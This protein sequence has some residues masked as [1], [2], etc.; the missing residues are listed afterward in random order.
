V[1][2]DVLS[3]RALGR[4]TLA[5]QLLLVRS[6]LPPLDAIEHLVGLQAQNPGDPYLA[7]W[8]RLD[9]F[10]PVA[11]GRLLEDRRTVRTVAMRATIHLVTADDCVGLRPLCQP[12]L[13]GELRRH[14]DHA[15]ALAGRDVAAIVAR[16]AE[17]LAAGP[18]TPA[19]LGRALADDF[20]DVAPAAMAYAARNHLTLVQVPPRGVWRRRGQ[21]TVTTAEAWLG[22]RDGVRP[23]LDDV[24][25]RYLRAFGP[26]LPADVAAWSRLTG[27]REVMEAMG[28][29]LRR[30]RDEHG[31][32]LFDAPDAPLPDE[33]VPAPVRVL[34]EYDNAL[35]SHQD[36][37]RYL[38]VD[39][40]P[41]ATAGAVHGTAL[42]DGAV[43]ATWTRRV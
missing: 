7:L 41:L 2:D 16:A 32:T 27:L 39:P 21:V 37:S 6:P 20:P 36:R 31:R 11:T 24:V 5:R 26:A 42:V 10:D 33:D 25:L 35:L 23:S 9:A 15:P 18:R 22:P 29:R 40:G 12:V 30:F 3:R 13:D 43:A 14:R 17:I 28:T 19:D 4:A 8:S 38:P 34:P 1:A